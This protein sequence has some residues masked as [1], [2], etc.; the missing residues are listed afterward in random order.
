MLQRKQ[1]MQQQLQAQTAYFHPQQTIQQ[2]QLQS[3][4]AYSESQPQQL[5]L[6]YDNNDFREHVL[7]M[8]EA[9]LSIM[10]RFLDADQFFSQRAQRQNNLHN[11]PEIEIDYTLMSDSYGDMDTCSD[12][13]DME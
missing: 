5:Q 7:R 1:M 10:Q 12:S 9:D 8:H 3:Q 13:D 2:Q 4:T 6:V 11:P